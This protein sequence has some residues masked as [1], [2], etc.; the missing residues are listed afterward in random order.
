MAQFSGRALS[1]EEQAVY[2]SS[3]S[4]TSRQEAKMLRDSMESMIRTTT[5]RVVGVAVL[6][7]A[8]TAVAA[9]FVAG[10]LTFDWIHDNWM[11]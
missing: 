1:E 6:A 5:H 9:L 4:F 3:L 2:S 10:Y 11:H 7:L 8:L